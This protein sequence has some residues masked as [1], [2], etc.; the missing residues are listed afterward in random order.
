MQKGPQT[1][2]ARIATALNISAGPQFFERLAE[3]LAETVEAAY[4]A[5]KETAP[6]GSD[7]MLAAAGI[8]PG[9]LSSGRTLPLAGADGQVLGEITLLFERPVLRDRLWED[10]LKIF[11]ARAAAEL[12]RKKAEEALRESQHRYKE[13]IAHS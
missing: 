11:A 2:I 13:F 3:Q 9:T 7:R 4:V 5:I 1:L 6:G 8:A 12:E 10:V